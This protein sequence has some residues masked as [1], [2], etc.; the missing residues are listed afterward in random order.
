MAV[1]KHLGHASTATEP[2]K[3]Q[4]QTKQQQPQQQSYVHVKLLTGSL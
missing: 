2:A 3:P 4:Q 1:C